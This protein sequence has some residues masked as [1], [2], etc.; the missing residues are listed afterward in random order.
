MLSASSP[1]TIFAGIGAEP[2]GR[3]PPS[4]SEKLGGYRI[5]SWTSPRMPLR[6]RPS[7]SGCWKAWSRF[8][9]T[10]PFVPA[11]ASTWQEPHFDANSFLPEMRSGLL[12]AVFVHALS[13]VAPPATRMTVAPARRRERESRRA[14][15]ARTLSTR[16]DRGRARGAPSDR[17]GELAVTPLRGGDHAGRDALPGVA[18]ARRGDERVARR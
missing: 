5:W 18:L 12:L 9:P 15:R 4:S 3:L 14:M 8:G 2:S 7:F 10:V 13:S 16:A 1:V 11:R 17:L 6:L